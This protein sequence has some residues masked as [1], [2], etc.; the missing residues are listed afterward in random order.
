MENNSIPPIF[1]EKLIKKF[2]LF[3]IILILYSIFL[4]GSFYVCFFVLS[5]QKDYV[6]LFIFILLLFFIL[7]IV[8]SAFF[9]DAVLREL[10]LLHNWSNKKI[11]ISWNFKQDLYNLNIFGSSKEIH[12][13]FN[14]SGSFFNRNF[15]LYELEAKHVID[16]RN[17]KDYL[18]VQTEPIV[19]FKSII[20]IKPHQ[21]SLARFFSNSNSLTKI[22]LDTQGLFDI[23][24]DNPQEA[25]NALTSEFMSKLIFFGKSM[26]DSI[27]FLFTPKGV[28]FFKPDSSVKCLFFAFSSSQKQVLKEGQKIEGFIGL[29]DLI[30]LLEKK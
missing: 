24:A 23:Y 25:L 3:R 1:Y 2:R 17:H 28:L 8:F 5:L 19:D 18:L 16:R 7:Y 13:C 10:T 29:L 26:K 30:N 9:Q 15:N 22:E 6:T 4:I 20:L 27:T 11:K 14:L 12:L 21:N